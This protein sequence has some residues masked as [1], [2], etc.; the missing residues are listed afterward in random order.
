VP[1]ITQK[2]EFAIK[3]E[4]IDV[5]AFDYEKPVRIQLNFDKIEKIAFLTESLLTEENT[6]SI[7]ISSVA[8]LSDEEITQIEKAAKNM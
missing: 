5:F 7:T 3:G 4:I 8:Y 2:G 1:E 6:N